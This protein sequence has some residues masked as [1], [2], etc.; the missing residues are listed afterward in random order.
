MIRR[1]KNREARRLP[2]DFSAVRSLLL[3]RRH[4][5]IAAAGGTAA[6]L[7]GL[8]LH[9]SADTYDPWPTLDAVTRHLLPSEPE[10]PGAT[11]IHALDYL[12]FVTNDR[13]IDQDDRD[14]ILQG[15]QWLDELA[16]KHHG[17]E[18]ATLGFDERE[19]LLRH[20]ALT[21]AGENWLSTLISYVLEA[22]LT[23]P[24]YGGNPDGIGWRWLE[25]V[26]GFPLPASGT[27]YVELPL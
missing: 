27:R 17:A 12:R 2:D 4:F 20:V 16:E 7:F 1:D 23:A 18:F 8:N 22:L 25:Y 3:D 24:A 6:M 11:E 14:F 26:P 15:N 9:A 13:W 5:M 10:S 21:S 19:K